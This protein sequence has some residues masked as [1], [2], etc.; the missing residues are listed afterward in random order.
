MTG[1][2][3]QWG[4]FVLTANGTF[5]ASGVLNVTWVIDQGTSD[6]AGLHGNGTWCCV[7]PLDPDGCDQKIM[8]SYSEQIQFAP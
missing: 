3:R 8:A 1:G 6:H 5:L 7:I 4:T 2:F